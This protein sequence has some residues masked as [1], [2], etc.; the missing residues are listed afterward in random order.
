MKTERTDK[1][2][3]RCTRC[4]MDITDPQISFDDTGVCNHC[5]QYDNFVQRFN[6]DQPD[7]LTK[8]LQE[9]LEILKKAGKNKQYDCVIGIS[10]GT[11][12]TYLA[13][14][15]KELGLRPLAVHVDCGWNS[16]LAVRNIENTVKKL[17][18]DLYTVVIDW[19]EMRDLQLAF[20]KS[21]VENCDIPTDHAIVSVLYQIAAENNLEYIISGSNFATESILPVAWGHTNIDATYIS[22]IQKVFGT[23]KLRKYPLMSIYKFFYFKVIKKIKTIKLLNYIPYNK[24]EAQS[25][26]KQQ[27]DWIDYGGKHHES[28]FTKFFQSYYLPRKFNYDKEIAHLSSLVVSGQITREVALERL[29][30]VQSKATDFTYEIGYVAKKIG[31]TSKELE[32]FTKTSTVGK[33]PTIYD[34]FLYRLYSRVKV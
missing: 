22:Y 30:I 34:S 32:N 13:Y 12:S 4:I 25:I 18:F 8:Q 10:G 33:I 21:G 11:D 15:V 6:L 20:F 29:V 14:K 17:G 3:Q 9:Q 27:L 23:K 31:I 26:I 1:A 16:D 2:Y 5:H 19:S 28:V 24:K 7:L